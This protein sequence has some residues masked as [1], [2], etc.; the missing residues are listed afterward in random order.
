MIDSAGPVDPALHGLSSPAATVELEL[1]DGRSSRLEIGSTVGDDD[2]K[3]FVSTDGLEFSV[4]VWE[5]ALRELLDATLDTLV[6][7]TA[8]DDAAIAPDGT[9]TTDDTVEA[10]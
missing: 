9:A 5:S 7:P 3:R 4:T 2:A 6:R 8:V 10:G 1:L